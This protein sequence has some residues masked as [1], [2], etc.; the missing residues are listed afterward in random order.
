MIFRLVAAQVATF[1]LLC[2][3]CL[4]SGAAQADIRIAV[5]GPMTGQFKEIGLQMRAGAAQAVADLNRAG[6]VNGERLV[7]DFADDACDEDKAVAVA[8]QLVGKGVVF[9]AGHA[10]FRASIP[11]SEVYAQAGIVQMSPV[12]T[13]PTFTDARPGAGV[14]RLAP[15]DDRQAAVAGAF[16]A[17]RFGTSRIAILNDKTAYGKG[18]AD[19]VKAVLNGLGVSE[20][21]ALGFDTGEKDYR[22][23][24]SQ[25]ALEAVDVVFVGGYAAETGTLMREMNRQGLNMVLM[26]GDAMMSNDFP[27]LAGPVA[28]GALMTYPVDPR[29]QDGAAELVSALEAE[30]RPADRYALTTYAAI[31]AWARAAGMA[32]ETGL[33]AVSKALR[34]GPLETILGPV[35]FDE[36]GDSNLPDYAVYEWQDGT[37]RL[38]D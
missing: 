11:A 12:T 7:L 35:T 30:G 15:R 24:V 16:L 8:N 34:S 36:K 22:Y 32:G 9:V 28:D 3:G 13:L 4:L 20:S 27:D 29:E 2:A 38:L 33:E 37:P 21:L 6:G 14:F 1:V 25:L 18:L 5:A 23:I 26:S 10:C 31:Q 19:Q 17:K